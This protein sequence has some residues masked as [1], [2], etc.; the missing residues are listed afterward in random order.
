LCF[1]PLF[2]F[3]FPNPCPSRR[4]SACRVSVFFYDFLFFYTLVL[5]SRRKK[6]FRG[7]SICYET[8]AFRYT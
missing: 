4:R 3:C 5:F 6:G 7:S 1:V 2:C 8:C